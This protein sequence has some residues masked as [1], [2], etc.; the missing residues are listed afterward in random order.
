MAVVC[1]IAAAANARAQARFDAVD[2]SGISGVPG[3][4]IITVRDKVLN[5]CYLVF[6]GDSGS[7]ATPRPRAAFTDLEQARAARDTRLAELLRGFE[8]ERGAIPGTIIP[9]P[10]KYDWQASAA[11]LEFALLVIEQQ[12]AQL[13]QELDRIAEASRSAMTAVSVACAPAA[14]RTSP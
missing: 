11:Q 13:E 9:D 2:Q 14:G 12:F 1:F 7:S 8:Q 5:A 3:L 4:R 6:V 10:L